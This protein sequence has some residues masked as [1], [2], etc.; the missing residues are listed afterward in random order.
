MNGAVINGEVALGLDS[1]D[2]AFGLG[3]MA[4]NYPIPSY[5]KGA[6]ERAGKA[7][8]SQIAA[9]A[10]KFDEHVEIFRTAHNWRAAHA[11]P[12]RRIGDELRGKIR[13][14]GADAITA[15][16][17]KRMASIRK[18]LARLT[19]KLTQIQDIAGCRAIV[20]SIAE[21]QQL[22]G[23]YR[24][25][26]SSHKLRDDRSYI[27]RPRASGYRSHHFVLEFQGG[28]QDEAVYNGLRIELQIRTQLQHSWATAVEAVGLVR[29]EDLKAGEGDA[30][31]LR[32]FELASSEF[33][34][35]EN[36]AT[37]PNAPDESARVLEIKAIAKKLK[38]VSTLE[39]L[40]Q[41]LKYTE[42]FSAGTPYKYY[43][44]QYNNEN[45]TVNVK[46]YGTSLRGA[47]Q[48]SAEESGDGAVSTVLVDIDKV[49]NL[50]LAYPNYF[51]DVRL[52]AQN[53]VRIMSNQ[54][55]NTT[56]APSATFGY[57]LKFLSGYQQAKV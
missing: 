57:D 39:S 45:K 42:S 25:G 5:S 20:S 1:A 31:W 10:D 14:V 2:D 22:V 47:E 56:A 4:V 30:D 38:A 19:V 35:A 41:A 46:G 43:L 27:E 49:E 34:L 55:L 40:N 13:K 33:A 37:V 11:F 28:Q 26:G 53:L 48:Y 12:M 24:N 7:L 8:S 36:C 9:H 54:P 29:S 23:I 21:L 17:I 51:L 6:V 32:L 52:F 3:D 50:R 16:R 15:A 18:K 44:I